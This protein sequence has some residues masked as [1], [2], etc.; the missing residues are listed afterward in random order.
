MAPPETKTLVTAVD[1]LGQPLGVGYDSFLLC[2]TC[3]ACPAAGCARLRVQRVD[4]ARVCVEEFVEHDQRI[5]G[6]AGHRSDGEVRDAAVQ[7]IRDAW[8]KGD[9]FTESTREQLLD[10]LNRTSCNVMKSRILNLNDPPGR[11]G[12]LGPERVN[13]H[14]ASVVDRDVGGRMPRG[15]RCPCS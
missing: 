7:P 3:R 11:V 13:Q 14:H 15:N 6:T 1:C 10:S 2:P 5:L 12:L 9:A 4:L 8:R